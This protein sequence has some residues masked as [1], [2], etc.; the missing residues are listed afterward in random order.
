VDIDRTNNFTMTTE[1]A[2]IDLLRKIFQP[3]RAHF[4]VTE[5]EL[6]KPGVT[7]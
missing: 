5:E 7:E 4:F 1:C 2:L 6:S 3:L